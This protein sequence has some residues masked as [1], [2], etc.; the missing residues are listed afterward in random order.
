MEVGGINYIDCTSPCFSQ[1]GSGILPGNHPINERKVAG[2]VSQGICLVRGSG[3]TVRPEVSFFGPV[4]RERA[5][6]LRSLVLES[7]Y[8]DYRDPS[9]NGVTAWGAIKFEGKRILE[10]RKTG[11]F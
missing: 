5:F 6:D 7:Y 11:G 1:R 8:S 10:S 2:V 3:E 9:Y 4:T